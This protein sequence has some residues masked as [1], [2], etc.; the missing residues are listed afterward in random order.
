MVKSQTT[1]NMPKKPTT[2]QETEDNILV[3]AAKVIGSAAGKI[4]S[5]ASAP[6]EARSA[7]KSTKV[8][9][10]PKKQRSRLPRRQKKAQQK[11]P[12]SDQG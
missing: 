8:G 4:A 11:T 2:R 1:T 3:S 6:P 5:L 9:K 7:A 12:A 10:L